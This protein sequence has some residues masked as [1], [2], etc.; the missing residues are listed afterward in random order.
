MKSI[1]G[2]CFFIFV[3]VQCQQTENV[4]QYEP[5]AKQHCGGCHQYADPALLPQAT[6]KNDVLP[7]MALRMGRD[8]DLKEKLNVRELSA[9]DLRYKPAQPLVSVADWEKIKAYYL[10]KAPET[11][12]PAP[13]REAPASILSLFEVRT[14]TLPSAQ[15]PNVTC[16][17]ID[18]LNQLVYAADEVNK[19]V[20]AT[21]ATGKPQQRFGEQPAVSDLQFLDK[22]NR[23]LLVTYIGESVKV[24]FQKNGYAQVVDLDKKGSS[25]LRLTQLYRP[26]QTLEADLD[27][28]RIPELITCEF[29]VIEGELS[30]WKKQNG[31]YLK[32][33]LSNTP[34]AIRSVL[35]DWNKDGR[36]DIVAL[37]SQSDERVVLYLN[38]GKLAFEEKTLLR[39]PPVYGSSYFDLADLNADGRLDIVYTCGDNADYSTVFKPYH[40]VYLFEN[41][42][43]ERFQQTMFYAMN[44]AYKALPRD[45]DLDGD[46]DLMAIAFYD[47]PAETPEASLLYFSNDNGTFKPY[48]IPIGRAGRWLALDAADLDHDG[49]I[50]FALGSHPLGLTAGELRK[51]W[52][53]STG[54]TILINQAA[55][56]KK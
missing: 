6:W 27:N 55:Q 46:L 48:T 17:K 16:V 54:L 49:D 8:E 36:L 1:I 41:Q 18:P 22:A 56:L 13:A 38:K 44:G 25:D 37:F 51:E 21:D 2:F 43:N 47:N 35:T 9:N 50:D 5:L 23:R 33:T 15:L 3:F 28:D 34:G 39:F 7:Y 53:N 12:A 32:K 24:T 29:G 45:V 11:F 30:V 10:A 26:T 4:A 31:K 42:G 52:A 19:A 20:W 14:A 40:G